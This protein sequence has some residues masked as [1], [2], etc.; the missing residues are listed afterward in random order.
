MPPRMFAVAVCLGEYFPSECLKNI[1]LSQTNLRE[2]LWPSNLLGGP[3]PGS[4]RAPARVRSRAELSLS[5]LGTV[6]DLLSFQTRGVP[7]SLPRTAL[8]TFSPRSLR[9]LNN[10]AARRKGRFELRGGHGG[11]LRGHSGACDEATTA[12]ARLGRGH[13]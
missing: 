5:S 7:A 8:P 1:Y 11:R 9:D 12:P 6:P 13:Y 2:L 4:E 10:T 3:D